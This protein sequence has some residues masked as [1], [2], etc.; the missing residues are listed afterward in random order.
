MYQVYSG[1]LGK[2]ISEYSRREGNLRGSVNSRQ[3]QAH[4]TNIYTP[5]QMNSSLDAALQREVHA[6]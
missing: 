6:G 1:F 4:I 3:Q 2:G 5:P